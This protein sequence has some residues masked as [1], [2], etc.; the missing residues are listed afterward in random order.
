V[1]CKT[2]SGKDAKGG[3]GTDNPVG[4]VEEDRDSSKG[5]IVSGSNIGKSDGGLLLLLLLRQLDSS[6]A[7]SDVEAAAVINARAASFSSFALLLSKGLYPMVERSDR[8]IVVV[9]VESC[10][11]RLE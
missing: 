1:S 3:V 7:D 5:I 9:A 4:V 8:V 6:R 10:S 11:W 2:S